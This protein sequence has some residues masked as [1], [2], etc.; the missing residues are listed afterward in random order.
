MSDGSRIHLN[1]H[2]PGAAIF[3]TPWRLRLGMLP[4]RASS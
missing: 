1:D 3:A 2:P 4:E